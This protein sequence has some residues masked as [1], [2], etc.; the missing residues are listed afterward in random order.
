VTARTQIGIVEWAQ[1]IERARVT[2]MWLAEAVSAGVAEAP[3]AAAKVA[4]VRRARLHAWHAELWKSV[5]PLLHN[6]PL[7]AVV[8]PGIRA[9]T[10]PESVL[11]RLDEDYG[12]WRAE[13]SPVAEVPIIRV[14]RLV[15]LEHESGAEC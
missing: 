10:N 3:D 5:V 11:E 1:R 8:A 12:A 9:G 4:L 2:E 13:A 14:L 7:D 15:V 6:S